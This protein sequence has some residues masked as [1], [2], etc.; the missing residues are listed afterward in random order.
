[1]TQWEYKRIPTDK[2]PKLDKLGNDGWE[3]CC[4][5]AD[6]YIFKRPKEERPMTDEETDRYLR[7]RGYDIGPKEQPCTCIKGTTG[8]ANHTLVELASCP[9]HD[10]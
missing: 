6:S 1:M 9:K 10:A 4:C 3:L 5:D 2:L 7:E 8:V